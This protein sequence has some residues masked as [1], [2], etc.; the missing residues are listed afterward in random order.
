MKHLQTINEYTRTVGFRYS[1]PSIK[2]NAMLLC[3]ADSIT[4]DQI[5]KALEYEKVKFENIQ[6]EEGENFID[7]DDEEVVSNYVVKFDF[8]VYNEKE[9]EAII[10]NI[11]SLLIREYEI[12]VPDFLFK[13]APML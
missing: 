2:I 8:Y 9:I 11:R 4:E 3:N 1:D 10:D 13:I 6:I 7:A 5:S 12:Q